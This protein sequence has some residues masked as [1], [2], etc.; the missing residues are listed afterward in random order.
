MKPKTPLYGGLTISFGGL[1]IEVINPNGCCNALTPPRRAGPPN[2]NKKDLF[3][4]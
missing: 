3:I 1:S 2:L 4:N